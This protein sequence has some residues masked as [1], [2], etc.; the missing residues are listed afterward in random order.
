MERLGKGRDF[1]NFTYES[2][3]RPNPTG[4]NPIQVDIFELES[5]QKVAFH[6]GWQV[7]LF[8]FLTRTCLLLK[9]CYFYNLFRSF[10]IFWAI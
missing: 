1:L 7:S 10:F 8:N 6:N 2:L 9:L 4:R 3:T 5:L